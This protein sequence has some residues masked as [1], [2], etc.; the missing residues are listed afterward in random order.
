LTHDDEHKAFHYLPSSDWL[1]H[2]LSACKSVHDCDELV[3]VLTQRDTNMQTVSPLSVT[4][5]CPPAA[6]AIH[7]HVAGLT[8]NVVV[9]GGWVTIVG[10]V[11]AETARAKASNVSSKVNIRS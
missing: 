5:Q 1:K 11:V 8:A 9:D 7:E 10:T 3:K 2:A 6:A 4:M